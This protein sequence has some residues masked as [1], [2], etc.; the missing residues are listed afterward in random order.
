MTSALMCFA[1]GIY[2]WYVRHCLYIGFGL[3]PTD[4]EKLCLYIFIV[5]H[6]ILVC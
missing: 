2:G 6:A 4:V 5:R 1:G 3:H